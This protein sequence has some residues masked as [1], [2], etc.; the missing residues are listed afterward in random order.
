MGAKVASSVKDYV[1]DGG[2]MCVQFW[3]GGILVGGQVQ[4]LK[5]DNGQVE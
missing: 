2:G 1:D 4:V 3:V 5:Q